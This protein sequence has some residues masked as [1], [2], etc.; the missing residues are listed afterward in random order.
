MKLATFFL[1][2]LIAVL[3]HGASSP[4]AATTIVEDRI[5][6]GIE[7][8]DWTS[9]R[10]AYEAGRHEVRAVEGGHAANN[11]GMKWVTTWDGRGFLCEPQAA[12]AGWKWG[13]E[14][15]AYGFPG[16]ETMPSGA[17]SVEAEGQRLSYHWDAGLEE[18]YVNDQRGVEHGFILAERPAGNHA[19]PLTF[20]MK[21][22]GGL[23]PEISEDAK[24]VRFLNAENASVVTY[25]GLKVW[26]ADGKFLPAHFAAA[27][28]DS[29]RL[30]VDE[31]GA[32]YPLT[33]DP[34][35]QQAYL[36]ASNAGE[37][38][39]FGYAVAASGNTVI[40]GAENEASSSS[41]VN[42]IPNDTLGGAGAAYVFV[43]NVAGEWSQQAYLKASNP[44]PGDRFGNSVAISG[45]T[46]VVGA[47]EQGSHS[48]AA[49][50][51][52][53]IGTSWS[54]Q[55]YLEAS[56]TDALDRFG[57]D[58]A[59]SG[60][61]IVVG[62]VGEDSNATGVNGNQVDCSAAE[63]GAAYVFT[64]VGTSWDQQA[65]LKAFNAESGDLFGRSVAIS[66]DTVVVGAQSESSNAMGVNGD[67]SNN[68]AANSGAAYVFV[69]N[70]LSWSQQAYLKPSN[71]GADDN[72]GYS[73]DIAGDTVVVGAAYEDS[74]SSG[75][76]GDQGNN[77]AW[78]S[79]AAYIFTREGTSWSQQAYLKASNAESG[80]LFGL[81]VAIS[82]GTV[83]VGSLFESSNATGVNG[84]HSNNSADDSGAAYVFVSNNLNWSQQAYLKS[85]NTEAFDGF[86]KSVAISG[87][88]VVVGA[89]FEDSNSSGVNGD[90][91]NNGA[92]GA[93]AAYT[94]LFQPT[95]PQI[96]TRPAS[97]IGATSAT[98][99][100]RAFPNYSAT[101]VEYEWGESPSGALTTV[102]IP[103]TFSGSAPVFP[104]HTL[105]GLLPG[106]EYRFR[107]KASNGVGP[108]TLNSFLT[109]TTAPAAPTVTTVPADGIT[110]TSASLDGTVSANGA[111]TSVTFTY[112]GPDGFPRTVAAL[113]SAF[114]TADTP[115]SVEITGLLPETMYS[116]YATASNSAGSTVS[117]PVRT[118]FTNTDPAVP[119]GVESSPNPTVAGGLLYGSVVQPDGG[120]LLFGSFTS[121][122]GTAR[123]R[124]ARLTPTGDLDLSFNPNANDNIVCAAILN[125]GKILIGGD[126]T[127]L[128]VTTR[129]RL[130]R[131]NANGTVDV[132]FDDPAVNA[133]VLCLAVQPDGAVLA[134]G[135]FTS[136]MGSTRN[137][138]AR[139]TAAGAL[140]AFN[141]NANA[142]VYAIAPQT[143]GSILLGGAFTTMG[144][145]AARSCLAKVNGTL[146]SLLT[147]SGSA[148]S[149]V[150]TI[151][152]QR[153]GKALVG[154]TFLS[155][156]GTPRSRLARLN[157]NGTL[158]MDFDPAVNNEVRSLAVQTNGKII[159][160]G[161]FN[162]VGVTLRNKLARITS[163]GLADGF[164]PNVAG[165][166]VYGAA[167]QKNGKIHAA[168]SFTTINGSV[169]RSGF[170]VLNN[171]EAF[172]TLEKRSDTH[173]R[174]NRAA[175]APQAS[176]VIFEKSTDGGATW[177]P[178]GTVNSSISTPDFI[179]TGI[180]PP[181]PESAKLRARARTSGGYLNGSAGL[182]ETVID[183]N[184]PKP[185]LTSV[186]ATDITGT[187][188]VLNC[189]TNANG[190][191]TGVF[192]NYGTTP[193]PYSNTVS[194][195]TVTGATP[196]PGGLAIYGLSPG[197]TYH[198]EAVAAN[199]GG[200]VRSTNITF[201]TLSDLNVDYKASGSDN[202]P[203]VSSYTAWGRQVNFSLDRSLAPGTT[204][205]VINNTGN[206]PIVGNFSNLVQ[207]QAVNLSFGGV[208][209]P[210][211][212]H[213][214]GGTGN[215]L[216]L[217]WRNTRVMTWGWNNNGQL[218]NGAISNRGIPSDIINDL[219]EGKTT[220]SLAAGVHHSVALCVDGTIATWGGNEHGQLGMGDTV[221]STSRTPVAVERGFLDPGIHPVAVAAG[222]YHTL[223]LFSDG[224]VYAW[225][226]NQ[227][228][229]VGD[230]F[231]PLDTSLPTHAEGVLSGKRVIGISAG[232]FH[233]LAVCDDGTV[234]AW[235]RGDSGQLGNGNTID[236]DL[237]VA[238]DLS[239]VPFGEKFIAVAAGRTH[240]MALTNG[241]KIF[242][243]GNNTNGQLG[244]GVASNQSFPVLISGVT[245]SA[246]HGGGTYH[247]MAT[248]SDGKLIAWGTNVYGQLG[249]GD[250]VN[251]FTPVETS[252]SWLGGNGLSQV[253]TSDEHSLA[254]RSDGALYAWGLGNEGR[255]GNDNISVHTQA[256]QSPV[257][258]TA[259]DPGD[260]W[261]MIHGGAASQHSLGIVAVSLIPTATTLA[262][263]VLSD[264]Q[265]I[266]R[267]IV[268]PHGSPTATSFDLGITPAYGTEILSDP[269][270]NG[271]GR[272]Q[273]SE[274]VTG[275]EPGRT[276]H[277]Q[278]KGLQGGAAFALGGD[279]TFTTLSRLQVWRRFHFEITESTGL[280]A[281][282]AD[283]DGDGI[284]NLL[285][286]AFGLHPWLNSTGELPQA[287]FAPNEISFAFN[288]PNT[289]MGITYIAEWSST[290][291]SD[292]WLP[293]TEHAILPGQHLFK[294][295]TTGLPRVFVR[296]RVTVP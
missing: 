188:A 193:S 18:W 164:N 141:P 43:R 174:L 65:Y 184:H 131:L 212:A 81:S 295:N 7:K 176:Y 291:E 160:G 151:A 266:L 91:G 234:A 34:V 120:S 99:N 277:Y 240:S 264:T 204:L 11:P 284:P 57:G 26:D 68:S 115:V 231:A 33:I 218:G 217:L 215:D 95:V 58:V 183:Y 79:G 44:G 94:F 52:E 265:A 198:F 249:T 129:N 67:H 221:L 154:G 159:I 64:R 110:H 171:E 14:L 238:V 70:G 63:S 27:E 292:S 256:P 88:L 13:L 138:V 12:D 189:V 263:E 53:R 186:A 66:G 294:L 179:L 244:I 274:L 31:K 89:W 5:P 148:D 2:T 166:D 267:G 213:Y 118:F 271:L 197:T 136:F 178:L 167:L 226:D 293:M 10:A 128:G 23:S 137:R 255:L 142:A 17:P 119:G 76:N 96:S 196:V 203:T 235:G 144:G 83:V 173:I 210:Y 69:R 237:P 228:G 29:F 247:S 222:G 214:Y 270:L 40:I 146:G 106:R 4:I 187:S 97:A 111:E 41:G 122:N 248:R 49:Y 15:A 163:A 282:D 227:H 78:A 168:G 21:V 153:D 230:N 56:N 152:L 242:T 205:M 87:D 55:A 107:A 211:V 16:S 201:T 45:D 254:F 145:G 191:S 62:A 181:L 233:S 202:A 6:E 98:L 192:F 9:I 207:G 30:L 61:T 85:S 194:G 140:D 93:G 288:E 8:S 47:S 59:I 177:T 209:Y 100:C 1:A 82:G 132:S 260:R 289:F 287:I 103:G 147:Y 182:T 101:T 105:S 139:F 236:E 124:I 143:D 48:G 37:D 220:V 126:F 296:L 156:N 290:L 280:A 258:V 257:V 165:G 75:V 243:W 74:N 150:F 279:L 51:F 104:P 190:N 251:S 86:G 20:T 73:L 169:P 172:E 80:D 77:S 71:T 22:R 113:P 32:R 225:G 276:Y 241:G 239:D 223:A 92:Y 268:G 72:F 3:A 246:I 162:F 200:V 155:M 84:D 38:D 46:I 114:T 125:D 161:A 135:D 158:D 121:V 35:A 60:D 272:Y 102:T 134:G 116:F 127:M 28:A 109:F 281:N 39:L 185:T 261:H 42:T 108:A 195:I 219:M 216:V 133:F 117:T 224:K 123:N 232:E 157:V 199:I 50:V 24:A 273:I 36:K 269:A 54:Q 252:I 180:S 229:Q 259:L 262:A 208:S 170:A 112:T 250:F 149:A 206:D 253:V 278:V 245:A 130:A 285:E 90:E 175:S 19:S 25:S 286:F 275:L 283:P